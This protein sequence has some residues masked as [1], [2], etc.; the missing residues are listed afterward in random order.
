[1]K[2]EAVKA[3][4]GQFRGDWV[5]IRIFDGSLWSEGFATRYEAEGYADYLNSI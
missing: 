1:M 2:Y 5:V 3:E 4:C